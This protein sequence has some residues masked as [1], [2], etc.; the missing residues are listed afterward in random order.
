MSAPIEYKIDTPHGEL[1]VQVETEEDKFIIPLPHLEPANLLERS[2]KPNLR[3]LQIEIFADVTSPN[4]ETTTT[5]LPI[6]EEIMDLTASQ[7]RNL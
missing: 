5:I 1:K 7:L 2:N 4:N 3:S 6:P